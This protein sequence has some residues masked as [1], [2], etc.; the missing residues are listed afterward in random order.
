MTY[1]LQ[2]NPETGMAQL[3]VEP[4]D[5]NAVAEKELADLKTAAR[6]YRAN[7]EKACAEYHRLAALSRDAWA[8]ANDLEERI[9]RHRDMEKFHDNDQ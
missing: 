1:K 3:V 7:A 4:E 9:E 2:P 5:P 8:K 6:A